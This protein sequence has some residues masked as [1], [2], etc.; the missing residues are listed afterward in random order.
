[1]VYSEIMKI[2]MVWNHCG[3]SE[4]KLD[5]GKDGAVIEVINV[6]ILPEEGKSS[7]EQ[8]VFIPPGI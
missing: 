3:N 1:M 7:A 2:K 5:G 6:K 4:N 8:Q